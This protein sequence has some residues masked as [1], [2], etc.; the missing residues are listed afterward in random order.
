MT[1][2]QFKRL[3]ES[4]AARWTA[5]I[6]V[7]FTMMCSYYVY[8]VVAPLED[9]LIKTFGWATV[10]Y[11]FFTSSYTFFNIFLFA[12]IIG[13]IFLDKMG[14]RITGTI[15]CLLMTVGVLIKV[16]AFSD[17]FVDDSIIMGYHSRTWIAVIGFAIFGMGAETSYV[18]LNKVVA[19]WF[20]GHELAL[21]MGLQV[22]L[23]RLGTAA[24]LA[25]S[26][27][28]ANYFGSVSAPIW[29]GVMLIIIGSLSFFVYCAMDRRE[30]RSVSAIVAT[31]PE[32]SFKLS[33]S[34]S[35]MTNRGFLIIA[36]LCVLFYSAVF[37][38]LKYA[39]K[40][41]IYKYGV[42][43]HLAGTIPAMLPFGAIILTPIFGRIFDVVG[44]GA[45]LMFIGSVLLAIVHLL[46]AAPFGNVWWVAVIIMILLGIAF[47]LVPSAMWPSVARIIPHK[48]LGTAFAII[49]YIQNLGLMLVPILIGWIIDRF[50]IR[51]GDSPAYDYTIPMLTFAVFG[52]LAAF[53]AWRLK[54]VD[55]RE[56]YGLEEPN[57][58]RRA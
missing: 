53:F 31:E 3:S 30:D 16:W 42:P 57:T 11:G 32:E 28:L 34:K 44:R 50:A 47:S 39:T 18:A 54:K 24:T 48:S 20:T 8:D 7:S 23:G 52:F 14:I 27:P 49:F 55:K 56:G 35:L 21:A 9:T 43:E 51:P 41:M 6:L 13:G 10:E 29:L 33:D 12:L 26:L 4:K 36:V 37:P 2:K 40:L 45:T 38:F 25:I 19:K 22:A 58:V 15:C 46:F 5:M 17:W 1:E